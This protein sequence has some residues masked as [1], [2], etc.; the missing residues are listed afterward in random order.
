MKIAT[1]T[2]R[3]PDTRRAAKQICAKLS[4]KAGYGQPSLV[5]VF[6]S[7]DYDIDALREELAKHFTAGEVHGGTSCRGVMTELEK[8]AG[9]RN[10]IGALAIW[11]E[12]GSYASVAA[13][14]DGN[15]RNAAANATRAALKKAGRAGEVPDLLWLTCAPGQEEQVLEGI[16]EVVGPRALI[17][18]GSAADNDV[19]KNWFQFTKDRSCKEGLVVTVMFSASEICSVYQSGHAPAG[20]RGR[21]TRADARRLIEIDHRPA[22]EVYFDWRR[23]SAPSLDEGSEPASILSD[24]TLA[25]LGRVS[26]SLLKVPFHLLMHPATLHADGSIDLFA[27]VRE[28]D[29]V[30]LMQ[31]T[32]EGLI[33]RAG[34]LAAQARS[35]I[36]ARGAECEGALIVYCGGCMLAVEYDMERVRCAIAEAL[37]PIPFLVMYSFGEQGQGMGDQS[38]HANLMISCTLFGNAASLA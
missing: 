16:K 29:E 11:D 28:G 35:E 25:P 15:P 2:E 12:E 34:R 8:N 22:G 38:Q 21:V 26:G 17:V 18:G 36:E 32:L 31:G 1:A 20:P 3:G 30:F 4:G 5:F 24:S 33:T 10:G 14:Y 13:E 6:A 23:C 37:G 9:T 7:S 19:S 27:N